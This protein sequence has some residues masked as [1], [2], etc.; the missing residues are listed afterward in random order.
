MVDGVSQ[1][2]LT[3]Y[4]F[5]NVRTAHAISASFV[6]DPTPKTITASAGPEGTIEPVGEVVVSCGSNQTFTINHVACY[7]VADVLVDGVSRGALK[8]YTFTDIN[9]PHTIA[10]S[11][12]VAPQYTITASAGPGG[13][14]E[15]VGAVLVISRLDQASRS[16]R[17]RVVRSRTWWWMASRREQ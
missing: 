7:R 12:V 17:P 13:I 16:H 15:P 10:V 3:S 9:A 11:F 4:T 14:I 1:G 2:A 8:S 6:S 5:T